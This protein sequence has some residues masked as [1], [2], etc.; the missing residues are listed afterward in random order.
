MNSKEFDQIDDTE[1]N[2]KEEK[3]LKKFID[4]C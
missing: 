3:T 2:D 4:D 1:K